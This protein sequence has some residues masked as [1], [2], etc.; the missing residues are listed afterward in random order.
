MSGYPAI[1][2]LKNDEPIPYTLLLLADEEMQAIDRYVHQSHIYVAE[3]DGK[4]V[5]VYALYQFN[6]STA[7]IKAIAVQENCQNRGI[8]KLML[9]HAV[10][11]AQAR[12]F[13]ELII[14]TPTVAEKQLT[15]YRKAGF[16]L[17]D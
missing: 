2:M 6:R 17:F 12:G 13:H 3:T 5:G 1:R 15:F 8:G 11:V 16:E 4:L 14:G 10:L 9:N 7:E